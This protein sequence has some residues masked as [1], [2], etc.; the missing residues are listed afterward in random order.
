MDPVP[1]EPLPGGPLPEERLRGFGPEAAVR[2]PPGAVA[3]RLAWHP[4]LRSRTPGVPG[5]APVRDRFRTRTLTVRA[6]RDLRSHR[7]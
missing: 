4:L 1:V 2:G 7:E 6:Q 3:P 5:R